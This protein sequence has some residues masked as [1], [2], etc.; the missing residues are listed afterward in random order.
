MSP[1]FSRKLQVSV[2]CAVQTRCTFFFLKSFTSSGVV[3]NM[4][5]EDYEVEGAASSP[6][7]GGESWGRTTGAGCSCR[8]G[9]TIRPCRRFPRG[10]ALAGLWWPSH[11]SGP[12]ALLGSQPR[13]L[14]EQRSP[15]QASLGK[16][17]NMGSNMRMLCKMH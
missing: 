14:A 12:S 1:V 15:S 9:Q 7:A 11:P 16:R 17:F 5:G 10:A 6:T 3:V 4:R 13:L 2:T 8:A